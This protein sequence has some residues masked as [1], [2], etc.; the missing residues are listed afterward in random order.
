[1]LWS[2]HRGRDDPLPSSLRL[3]RSD[4]TLLHQHATETR[5]SSTVLGSQESPAFFVLKQPDF[6]VISTNRRERGFGCDLQCYGVGWE[7]TQ[8]ARVA[9]YSFQKQLISTY[10]CSS[11]HSPPE[12]WN[13]RTTKGSLILLVCLFFF[14][15]PFIHSSTLAIIPAYWSRIDKEREGV[16]EKKQKKNTRARERG[17]KKGTIK[18][19]E[20]WASFESIT[21]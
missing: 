21:S 5:E 12:R 18:K 14:L 13:E 2:G 11:N 4:N 6:F 1:M 15:P 8:S 19:A 9:P 16:C 20:G 10:Y 17:K 7:H 3:P